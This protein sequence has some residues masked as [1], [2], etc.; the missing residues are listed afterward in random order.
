MSPPRGDSEESFRGTHIRPR[1]PGSHDDFIYPFTPTPLLAR[2]RNG[3][4]RA[5][6]SLKCFP[7]GFHAAKTDAL[8]SSRACPCRRDFDGSHPEARARRGDV[9]DLQSL[10]G[11]RAAVRA[12]T[13]D[14]CRARG[15]R[16]AAAQIRMP[17]TLRT[18]WFCRDTSYRDFL[19][20][21]MR[22]LK[23]NSEDD[24]L[25]GNILSRGCVQRGL[26]VPPTSHDEM[27]TF[28]SRG[29]L[30]GK[31]GRFVPEA[32]CLKML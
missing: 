2:S 11:W 32:K 23:V 26:E 5:H 12:R 22:V 9:V 13:G 30:S 4:C 19:F 8:V 31:R 10:T 24:T 18:P 6:T 1:S 20:P 7:C 25:Q 3:W 28:R 21:R 15:R 27:T 29:P 17:K 14:I 16:D